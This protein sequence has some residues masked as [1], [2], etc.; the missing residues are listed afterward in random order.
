MR[1]LLKLRH[2][3]MMLLIDVRIPDHQ[4]SKRRGGCPGFEVRRCFK[5]WERFPEVNFSNHVYTSIMI[6]MQGPA[7]L[8][9]R[10]KGRKSSLSKWL[11][12]LLVS[13]IQA[14]WMLLRSF[15]HYS[16]FLRGNCKLPVPSVSTFDLSMKTWLLNHYLAQSISAPSTGLF[17]IHI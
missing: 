3:L 8:Q 9:E 4:A 7:I 2:T 13:H 6:N 14:F 11:R 17:L 5:Q 10:N 12:L 16:V 15:I 1:L